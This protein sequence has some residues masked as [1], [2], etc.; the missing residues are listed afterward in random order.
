MPLGEVRAG[1]KGI[2]RTVFSGTRIEEF[3]VEVL[4]VLENV[5]PRQS[6]ILGRLSGGPLAHSG[7]LQGMSG[8][9]VYIGG[10]LVG[11]VA[12]AFAFSKDPIAGIRP[13][14]EMVRAPVPA[15]P[16]RARTPLLDANPELLAGLAPRP[17]Y[18]TGPTRMVEIATPLSMSGFTARTID[19][20]APQ[21]RSLGLEPTQGT[22][23]GA[24]SNLGM[25]DPKVVTPGSMISVQLVTG[26]LAVGADGTVTHV[27]GDRVYAFGHRFL[28]IGAVEMP[29]ARSE[30][31]AL[32]P[33]LNTSF[34]ISSAR[35]WM[36]AI[37][38]DYSTA[39]AG[40]LGRRAPMVPMSITVNGDQQAK[41]EIQVVRERL[42]TPFL[43]QMATYSAIDGT[44]RTV[45][46]ST[47]AA[48]GMIEFANA[49]S[50]RIDTI[51]SADNG[52]ALM[53]S[54]SGALPAGYAMQ[55]GFPDLAIRRVVLD[56][57][58]TSAR[59]QYQ[60]E[61]VTVSRPRIRP[62]ES[63]DIRV[64]FTGAG[65]EELRRSA[66]W[67]APV[68]APNGP[69]NFTVSE[70]M[71]SN[72]VEFQHML[73][74]P[75]ASAAQARALLDGIRPNSVATLRIWR[76]DPVFQASGQIMAAPPPSV[77]AILR[78]NSASTAGVPAAWGAK[79]ASVEFRL[80]GAVVSGSKSA[81]VEVKE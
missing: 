65:G 39:V 56:F 73:L 58:V 71:I 18:S 78:R 37:T 61:N 67:R 59:K 27:V 26:D 34:K 17:E 52:T 19:Q 60:V 24:R 5:G 15:S 3:Q 36:G 77:A 8:S 50:A 81:Q 41:Y 21:L 63:V 54:L 2:G 75:P 42:L 1:M 20:F 66:T 30:V 28:S 35:E 51:Y 55:S 68:G 70:A 46:P 23:G 7:V 57:T 80:D 12:T 22:L 4:G 14:E 49:P 29:F 69:V 31:V 47:V 43:M 40:R 44:E 48:K 11:A 74:Q 33:N 76:A 13:I 10:R 79:L 9:P 62:G 32:L 38:A 72:L 16:A 45:G 6:L 64:S 53:A 25:G